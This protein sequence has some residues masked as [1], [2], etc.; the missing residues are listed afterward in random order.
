MNL[1]KRLITK[2]TRKQF[3]ISGVMCSLGMH[4]WKTTMLTK[5]KGHR[6]CSKCLKE[7]H[8]MYDMCYGG[9]YWADGKYW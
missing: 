2:I 9:T 4:K 1:I 7:Q 5:V 8:T 3:A 6:K